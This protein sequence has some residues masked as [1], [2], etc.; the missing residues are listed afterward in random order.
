MKNNALVWAVACYSVLNLSGCVVGPD[1]QPPVPGLAAHW[2]PVAA[3]AGHGR[4]VESAVDPRWW[5]GFGDVQLSALVREAQQS[6]FDVQLAASR[7]E[8]SLAIR[9]QINA[10]TL[11]EVDGTAAYSRSR[12]SQQG[13]NDPS[14]HSGK[15]AFNL[16]NGGLGFS[17]EADLWG[18]VKRS[19]EA[20]DASVRV[21]A[22]DR[23]GV[24]LLVIVQTAQHYIQLRGTQ[25]AL[26]VVE[27]NLQ[28][29]RRSL[30]LTRLQLKEGVATDLQV[31]EAAAQ[32]AEIEAR[33]APL[34]QRS[35]QL[36]NALSMLLAREP[37]ALQQ[38]L[39]AV[40]PVPA[41]GADVPIGLP[42]ELA[43]R[44][45]DIRRAEAQLHAA[46]AAIG[47]AE[48]DFYPRITLSGSLGLQAM[49][50]SD[51]G[52]WGSRSFAFGPGLSVP[53][54]EGGRLQGALQLQE[55]RQQEAGI[56]Y[57]K[58]VLSAW[59]EV[60]DALVAYQAGQR[61][62]DSLQQAVVHS[63]RALDSVHQ[64]YVQGTVDFLNVLTVQNALLA[65]EAAL[66]D[67]TAQV[68]LSLVD[69]FGALG[70]GWPG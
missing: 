22:E 68:S 28:I 58:T 16:W 37:R 17:W 57:Q 1:F 44:R 11:P 64:Q 12:N 61:R 36:I 52:S 39:S 3:E 13:L 65:N 49:Q 60:D 10:D 15:Q 7:L 8:Q 69:V 34:Q 27:Q 32:V 9:R 4:T 43:Q 35:A 46:T 67:S 6:N 63:Q 41:Y 48:A 38:Q 29:A 56:A 21:A 45:P 55:G 59:H 5:D 54:F 23:H 19:V 62:R 40:T 42:S 26:A 24:Q 2:A 20:A 53:V 31:S 25:Q 50:L 70:G 47:M 30:E 51:L 18:R 33:M 14:G 66:V